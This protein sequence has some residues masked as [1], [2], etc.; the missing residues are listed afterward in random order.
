MKKCTICKEQLGLDFFGK[1]KSR[2]D[3]LSA[4]CKKC[5][6]KVTQARKEK[7][8]TKFLKKQ[9]EHQAKYRSGLEGEALVQ[10][11]KKDAERSKEYRKKN[12]DKIKQWW[13]ENVDKSRHY[14]AMRRARRIQATPEWLTEDHHQQIKAIYVH[15]KE[16]EVLTGDKYH[17]D[18]IVPL[19]GE[20]ISGLHVPWNLQVLPADLNIAKS[21]SYG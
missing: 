11:R 20:N 14:N 7:D 21:N 9:K 17:V 8:P 19:K 13:S 3:G 4:K 18:H 10:Y 15:A 5:A 6:K 2:G 16:C 12:P 1:D